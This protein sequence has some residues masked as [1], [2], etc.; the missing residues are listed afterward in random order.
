VTARRSELRARRA[1][2]VSLAG[3]GL[4]LIA[5]VFDAAP[6]FVPGIALAAIGA[7]APVWV[8]ASARGARI[9]R[10]LSAERVVEDEPLQATI[11]VRRPFA[12][13]GWGGLE[14]VDPLTGA[15]LRLGGAGSPLRRSRTARI[16]VTARFPRRGEQRIEPPMLI[17][18]DPFALSE[19]R[20][21][22]EG[23]GQTVLV[24]PRTGPVRWLGAPRATRL[25]GGM[26]DGSA[27]T[28]AATDLD[29]LRPYRPGTPASRIHWPAVARGHGL[30]ER[31][32][33]A[34]GDHRPLVVLDARERRPADPAA[35]DR[36]PL[37]AA[38]RAA[39][40]LVLDL[41]RAG[42]CGLLLSGQSR[43]VL[44]DSELAAWPA[45]HARLAIV[46]TAAD[47]E[48]SRAPALTGAGIRSGPLIYVAAASHERLAVGLVG[49][50]RGP[51]LL[52]VPDSEVLEGRPRG[53]GARARRVLSVCG[54]QGFLLGARR[55]GTDPERSVASGAGR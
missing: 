24:L 54:C 49:A 50:A 9:R 42:G 6:L 8:V 52:V 1:L 35:G 5:F 17:A 44:V 26:G 39:A 28:L 34:D 13:I 11:E 20:A 23:T 53:V 37:D 47:P 40:S 45:A 25:Q 21:T 41:A 33:Q 14:A 46:G 55:T 18:A 31:R 22:G 51:V 15:Q 48:P 16:R 38:V 2:G 43:P 10:R 29:G 19:F 3:L 36:S 4:V 30:I 27:E 12:L 32:L 7:L